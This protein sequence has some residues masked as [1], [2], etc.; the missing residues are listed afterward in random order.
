[1]QRNIPVRARYTVVHRNDTQ[2]NES[3]SL[4]LYIYTHTH[5]IDSL[6]TRFLL[7]RARR[8]VTRNAQCIPSRTREELATVGSEILVKIRSNCGHQHQNLGAV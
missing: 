2:D 7:T 1:M 3:L 8:T 4:Y 5:E 6:S